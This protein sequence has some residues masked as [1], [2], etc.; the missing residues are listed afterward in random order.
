[1][2]V[3]FRYGAFYYAVISVLI[4]FL[5]YQKYQFSKENHYI[6]PTLKK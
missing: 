2:S 4:E 6:A 3:I 5:V 1:M